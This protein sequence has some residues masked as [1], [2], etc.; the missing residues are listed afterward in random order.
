[1]LFK[2]FAFLALAIGAIANEAP[3]PAPR[4]NAEALARG[5]PASPPVPTQSDPSPDFVKTCSWY[6]IDLSWGRPTLSAVCKDN[7]GR[8]QYSQLNLNRC[9]NLTDDG[10]L[11]CGP[12]GFTGRSRRERGDLEGAMLKARHG[13]YGGGRRSRCTDCKSSADTIECSCPIRDG[14]RID[15]SYTL[16]ACI[17][18]NNGRL[19]CG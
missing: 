3:A 4:T 11:A 6:R 9:I 14:G 19:T 17:S 2:P 18:N 7:R 8:D 16:G 1:M 10:Q 13:N 15:A 12:G 5:L